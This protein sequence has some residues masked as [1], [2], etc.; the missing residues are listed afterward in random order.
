[1]NEEMPP[2]DAVSV[3]T[4]RKPWVTPMLETLDA[5]TST[6]NGGITDIIENGFY[7]LAAS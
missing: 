6:E 1:M 7:H 5:S 3:R 2:T 4:N